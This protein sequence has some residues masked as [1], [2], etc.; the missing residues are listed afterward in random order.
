MRIPLLYYITLFS[1]CLAS[2]SEPE[3]A[4]TP[5]QT[6]RVSMG[7]ARPST[8]TVTRSQLLDAE[9]PVCTADETAAATLPE[10]RTEILDDAV[11][12][13]W[14]NDD[15]LTVWAQA[16]DRSFSFEAQTFV[17]A[18]FILPNQALFTADIKPM[19]E[20]TYRYFAVYPVPE[21]RSGSQ[22]SYTIPAVQ[23]GTY[24]AEYDLL[25]AEPVEGAELTGGK[26]ENISMRMQH[27]CHALRIRIPE[28]RNYWGKPVSR[29]LVEF[30]TPVTGQLTFDAGDPTVAP[31]LTGGSNT[32]E[33][34]FTTPLDASS[35]EA[36]QYAWVF[37]APGTLNGPIAF[38]PL[39]DDGYCAETLSSPVITKEMEAGHITP[40]TLSISS[41]EQPVTWIDFTVD[42]SQLG[43]TVTTLSVTAPAGTSFR[44]NQATAVL[45]PSD[46]KFSVGYY[47]KFYPTQMNGATLAVSY[48][49]ENAEVKDNVTLPASLIEDGRNDMA[50]KAPWLLYE[51][52]SGKTAFEYATDSRTSNPSG[53]SLDQYGFEAGWTGTRLQLSDGAMRVSV[54][55]ETVAQYPGRIDTPPLKN[56]KEGHSVNI[57]VVFNAG[58]NN[59]YVFCTSGTITDAS[60][61]QGNNGVSANSQK[62][63]LAVISGISFTNIP[64]E[65]NRTINSVANNYRI[66]WVVERTY[67][68]TGN[69]FTSQ[70][71]YMY[72]DNIR[73]SI[74]Q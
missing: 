30:P 57:K 62:F 9:I 18:K 66:S 2:C 24:R 26:E 14:N 35:T 58:K 19:T 33:L 29:L 27:M 45:T 5:S 55:H 34:Q 32:I 10:T 51:D 52:F 6:M 72:L 25:A 37:V 41:V 31:T 73:V 60:A 36:P 49:S 40:V 68:F 50:V 20:G 4:H 13:K 28:G 22:V 47:A 65:Y 7:A 8:P 21:Q 67:H 38:T 15:S 12:M 74:T 3:P 54:R 46:D 56:I 11:S 23:D 44:G 17:L 61:L 39:F 59:Q 42:S 53:I 64:N 48:E 16:S 1:V 43:E 69:G 63:D 71:W 70:T